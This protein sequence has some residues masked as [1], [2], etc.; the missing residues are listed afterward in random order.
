[1]VAVWAVQ[2]AGA[3]E[4][5]RT[6][7]PP[8]PVRPPVSAA[9]PA[10]R[11]WTVRFSTGGASLRPSAKAAAVAAAAYASAAYSGRATVIV[12]ADGPRLAERRAR[13][14]LKA[15]E[16][17]GLDKA[18]LASSP[19]WGPGLERRRAAIQVRFGGG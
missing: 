19:R 11:D 14:L 17:A 1:M 7:P 13:V 10:P 12:Y 9:P 15:L 6:T 8:P 2:A 4:P 5:A 18:R 16:A 3:A